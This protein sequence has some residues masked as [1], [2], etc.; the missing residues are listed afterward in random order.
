VSLNEIREVP[1]ENNIF[2]VGPS[3]AGKE[4][5]ENLMD[6]GLGEDEAVK[7]VLRLLE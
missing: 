7:R 2:L 4:V 3:G 5:G 1:P 6:A